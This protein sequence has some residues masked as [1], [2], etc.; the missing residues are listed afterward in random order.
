M[1]YLAGLIIYSA[2]FCGSSYFTL[3]SEFF[4]PP[5]DMLLLLYY[6][7]AAACYLLSYNCLVPKYRIARNISLFKT[8]RAREAKAGAR[9]W[10][11]SGEA[12]RPEV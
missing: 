8:L 2:I 6:V 3:F 4:P 9:C 10:E 1:Y 12:K 5:S 11:R 7:G